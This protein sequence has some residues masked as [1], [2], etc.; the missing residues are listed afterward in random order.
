[1]WTM[2]GEAEAASRLAWN[3]VFAAVLRRIILLYY[4]FNCT[5]STRHLKGKESR[6]RHS[7][8]GM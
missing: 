5:A 4:S 3:G 7:Q 2:T 8:F 6:E 1:M